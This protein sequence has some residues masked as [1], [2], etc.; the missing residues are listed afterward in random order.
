MLRQ[1]HA[2]QNKHVAQ[3]LCHQIES[4]RKTFLVNHVSMFVFH[5]IRSISIRRS[6]F[7]PNGNRDTYGKIRPMSDFTFDELNGDQYWTVEDENFFSI[8][9]CMFLMP[10]LFS[11]C[12]FVEILFTNKGFGFQSI[13]DF[14][15]LLT[16]SSSFIC[17]SY[18]IYRL[19][20]SGK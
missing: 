17:S 18:G 14:F 16:S 3:D 12:F 2:Q 1:F 13:E 6:S 8:V 5:T 9:H 11:T 19:S 15:F 10:G 7:F 20:S 4:H